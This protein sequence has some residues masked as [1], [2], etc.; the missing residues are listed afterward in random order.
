MKKVFLILIILILISGCSNKLPDSF[1]LNLSGDYSSASGNR[2]L[3]ALLTFDNNQVVDGWQT[4]D[5][6]TINSTGSCEYIF[7]KITNR[8]I[9]KNECDE[10]YN[11]QWFNISNKLQLQ[12]KIDSEEITPISK[13]EHYDTCYQIIK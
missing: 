1:I 8:W 7:D 9:N 10:Y 6:S 11:Y 4:Y 13:C 3:N 2:A 5:W 12:E